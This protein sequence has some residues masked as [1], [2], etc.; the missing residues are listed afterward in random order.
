MGFHVLAAFVILRETIKNS[1][2]E[3]FYGFSASR[4]AAKNGFRAQYAQYAQYAQCAQ[5]SSC[6]FD[7]ASLI[8]AASFRNKIYDPTQTKT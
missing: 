7:R 2:F 4:G 6:V 8:L 1:I 3:T 5:S